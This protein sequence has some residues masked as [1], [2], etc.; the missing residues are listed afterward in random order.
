M[1]KK[2]YMYQS[3]WCKD[4]MQQ[5]RK[6]PYTVIQCIDP[7]YEEKRPILSQEKTHK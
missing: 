3:M 5:G 7:D 1:I 4:K 6:E 2:T